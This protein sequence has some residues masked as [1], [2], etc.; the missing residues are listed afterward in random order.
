[1]VCQYKM[2][3]HFC[4]TTNIFAA[5]MSARCQ[6]QLYLIWTIATTCAI[7]RNANYFNL[8]KTVLKMHD[9]NI[10][11]LPVNMIKCMYEKYFLSCFQFDLTCTTFTIKHYLINSLWI[12][13]AIWRRRSW[14][15]LVQIMAWSLVA[16]R[17]IPNQCWLILD[18]VLQY[19][20][21]DNHLWNT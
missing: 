12:R 1:M 7:K 3:K 15:L 6:C 11:Y 9:I 18:D 13:D 21:Q 17:H 19:S 14:S 4:W 10:H 8:C 16:L 20:F 5:S 2:H